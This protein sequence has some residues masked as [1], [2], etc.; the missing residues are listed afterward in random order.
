MPKIKPVRAWVVSH[1]GFKGS[2]YTPCYSRRK[3]A[4]S[5]AA[6]WAQYLSAPAPT[7][8]RVE[9]RVIQPKRKKVSR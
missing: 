8:V 3:S 5:A 7:V 6:S 2:A 1:E 9:I 4:E